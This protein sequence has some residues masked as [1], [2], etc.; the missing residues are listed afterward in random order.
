MTEIPSVDLGNGA[1]MPMLGFG[2][3][4]LQ[5]E[6]AYEATRHALLVGY[7]HIDTA[8]MYRNEEQVGRAIADSG[9]DRAELFVTTKL[10]PGNAG[11][12]RTTISESLKALGTDYVD[13]W[14]VHWPP[15]GRNLV[16]LWREFLAARDDGLTRTV[17]VS[18]YSIGQIDDLIDATGEKPPSTRS[19][20][21]PPATTPVCWPRTPNAAWRSRATARSRAPGCATAR[22]P[23]SPTST[24][25]PGPGGPALAHRHRRHRHP[26]S[27][28]PERIEQNFDLF[29]FSLT[30]KN[31]P[32]QQP[33]IPPTPPRSHPP[34]LPPHPA[35]PTRRAPA[36]F[37]I[38]RAPTPPSSQTGRQPRPNAMK[39]GFHG[40]R[41]P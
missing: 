4:Q 34:T 32:P 3:W 8:T 26:R 12:A 19:R 18:N 21:A 27:A 31:N 41:T 28:R 40:V 17:G 24:V 23:R 30:P 16:P 25:S 6:L 22:W 15:R 2:T 39:L 33:L 38:L 36:P 11:R 5:G 1:A 7:R 10:P 29:G 9:V 13:L 14:L 35:N 20:G 37:P